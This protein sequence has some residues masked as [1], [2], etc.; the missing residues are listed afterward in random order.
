VTSPRGALRIVPD[1]IDQLQPV[2]SDPRSLSVQIAE[3]IRQLISDGAL[4]PG[5]RLPTEAG[6]ASRFRVGRTTVREALKPLAW[7]GTLDNADID[8]WLGGL[9]GRGQIPVLIR[10]GRT[11][12]DWMNRHTESADPLTLDGLF[13]AACVWREDG[14][15]R[16]IALPFWVAPSALHH[17][18][19]LRVG[20]D[21]M[22]GFLEC[23]ARAAQIG[24]EELNRLRRAETMIADLGGT[25]RS[26][27]R[28]AA[29]RVI[30][31]PVITARSLAD[32]L[33][34][35]PQAALGL[36]RQLLAAGIV[37]EATGR[38]AWR[39]FVVA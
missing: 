33:D 32:G 25:A 10:A 34:V 23:V 20:V 39:A 38:A 36:L 1:P 6:F 12:R 35:S 17:R 3:R 19:A 30:R 24:L 31:A 7:G 15:G 29:D 4:G 14:F 27:L 37:R 9:R 2:V 26:R 13:L 16:D 28:D 18:L 21:W 8:D 5:E 11:A 22:A